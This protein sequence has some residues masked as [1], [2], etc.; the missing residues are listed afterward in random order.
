MYFYPFKIITTDEVLI[1]FINYLGDRIEFMNYLGDRGQ[2]LHAKAVQL[3]QSI[4]VNPNIE[5]IPQSRDSFHAGFQLYQ[6]RPDKGYSLTDCISMTCM[7]RESLVEVLTHDHHFA[8]EGFK[9][10]LKKQE[11]KGSGL[12]F[13]LYCAR[14][15]A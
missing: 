5:I 13:F 6:D 11:V 3:V 7:R 8:Q 2:Y 15:I 12:S 1:K 9:L 14:L 10:L 4:L